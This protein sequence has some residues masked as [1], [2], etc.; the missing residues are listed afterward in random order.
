MRRPVLPLLVAA[1]GLG[2][3]CGPSAPDYTALAQ[4]SVSAC[5]RSTTA[6]TAVRLAYANTPFKGLPADTDS[7]PADTVGAATATVNGGVVTRT[8]PCA[9]SLLDASNELKNLGY[10]AYSH[11]EPRPHV[12]LFQGTDRYGVAGTFSLF[13]CSFVGK[14]Q[15][16]LNGA[17]PSLGLAGTFGTDLGTTPDVAGLKT[18]S[19]LTLR[20]RVIQVDDS[21]ASPFPPYV[22]GSITFFAM[23]NA[24]VPRD[25]SGVGTNIPSFATCGVWVIPDFFGGCDTVVVG[26]SHI[27]LDET[28]GTFR[29]E[30]MTPSPRYAFSGWCGRTK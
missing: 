12:Y 11:I 18:F 9:D 29:Q 5:G 16:P 25:F 26:S 3:G 4:I 27:L 14:L 22:D 15:Q 20:T 17:Y 28:N 2:T 8:L 1:L 30:P 19:S 7:L 6:E 13:K 24:I 10:T 21:P 23:E